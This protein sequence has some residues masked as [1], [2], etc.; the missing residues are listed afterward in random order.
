MRTRR[1]IRNN[2]LHYLLCVLAFGLLLPASAFAAIAP[3][4]IRDLALGEGDARESAIASIVASGDPSAQS[5]LQ[6]MQGGDV[7]T[8]LNKAADLVTQK[9][10]AQQG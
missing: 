1:P 5:L 7:K 9:T 8:T 10:A 3:E 4:T 6:A 2:V